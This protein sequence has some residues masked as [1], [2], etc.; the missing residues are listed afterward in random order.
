MKQLNQRLNSAFAVMIISVVLLASGCSQEPDYQFEENNHYLKY[1]DV[2][3]DQL[4]QNPQLADAD[5]IEFFTY[6]CMHCQAFHP[7]LMKWK[8]KNA[9]KTIAYVPVVWNET[10]EMHAKVFYLIQSYPNAEQVH[11]QLFDLVKG[12]SRTDSLEEQKV[13]FIDFLNQKGIQPIDVLNA[14][15]SSELDSKT[16]SSVMLA[17]R[18]EVSGTP[19]LI[20]NGQYR[21]NNKALTDK[22]QLLQI[23]DELF[24]K[25]EAKED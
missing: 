16:A 14:L 10:T 18:F 9:D 6:G 13:K 21:V 8:K 3:T 12:F 7:E 20:V 19:S 11:H 23:V 15:D 4:E 2:L 5:L 25:L 1:E 17:K 22:K 24:V